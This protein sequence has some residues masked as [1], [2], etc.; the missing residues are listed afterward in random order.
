MVRGT[1][2]CMQIS[3]NSDELIQAML[4]SGFSLRGLRYEVL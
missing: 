2:S 1:S 3:K 4:K